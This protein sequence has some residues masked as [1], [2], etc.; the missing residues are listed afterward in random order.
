VRPGPVK[1]ENAFLE[2]RCL[3]GEAGGFAT[4]RFEELG[5]FTFDARNGLFE[6]VEL[7]SHLD[8]VCTLVK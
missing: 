2:N 1:I 5:G 4:N 3:P 6:S 7:P 8:Y